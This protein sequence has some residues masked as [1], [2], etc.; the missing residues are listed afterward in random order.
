VEN[1]GTVGKIENE[2]GTEI[3]NGE[4]DE[5]ETNHKSKKSKILTK[6]SN[7]NN[8]IPDK[9]AAKFKVKI[10]ADFKNKQPPAKKIT[11][12]I[13]VYDPR[14]ISKREI[15]KL[16]E[17]EPENPEKVLNSLFKTYGRKRYEY[18]KAEQKAAAAQHNKSLETLSL[19]SPSKQ[20]K[21]YALQRASHTLSNTTHLT[22]GLKNLS[23]TCYVNSVVQALSYL[24]KFI[25][26]FVKLN[27]GVQTPETTDSPNPLAIAL[28][29]QYLLKEIRKNDNDLTSQSKNNAKTQPKSNSNKST[30]SSPTISS[31]IHNPETFVTNCVKTFSH[32]DNTE[33]HDVHEFIVTLLDTLMNANDKRN[34]PIAKNYSKIEDHVSSDISRL[35]R[36][37][38]MGELQQLTTCLNCQTLSKTSVPLFPLTVSIEQTNVDLQE[39]VDSNFD[40]FPFHLLDDLHEVRKYNLRKRQSEPKPENVVKNDKKSSR[41]TKS[42]NEVKANERGNERGNKRGNKRV[43]TGSPIDSSQEKRR[44]YGG[45]SSP[46]IGGQTSRSANASPV[47]LPLESLLDDFF[48]QEDLDV[49]CQKCFEN[50]KEI[51]PSN[52][53]QLPIHKVKRYQISRLPSVVIIHINRSK[54]QGGIGRAGGVIKDATRVDI[55]EELDFKNYCRKSQHFTKPG[56]TKYLLSAII[57]HDGVSIN[58]GHYRVYCMNQYSKKWLHFN[59]SRLQ[60]CT[61]FEELKRSLDGQTGIGSPY[62]LF[63]SKASD[64]KDL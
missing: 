34:Y 46:G 7:N 22:K 47:V 4:Y 60:V 10:N 53:D 48:K 11:E 13:T 29:L 8:N 55:N 40:D 61:S 52:N 64:Y 45:G 62:L 18:E 37:I 35:F 9:T 16:P 39:Q 51:Y 3:E 17:L 28:G 42:E 25:N 1:V 49:Y 33:Q 43:S 24:P 26:H 5:D 15:P 44:K 19:K 12:R 14:E 23:N 27:F 41:L 54:F 63:Y 30:N 56:N 32:F 21:T 59:D 2:E 57:V 38:F 31:N 58:S 20:D 36:A 50:M 6:S